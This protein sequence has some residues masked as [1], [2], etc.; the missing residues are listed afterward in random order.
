MLSFHSIRETVEMDV[1]V[2]RP[3]LRVNISEQFTVRECMRPS[4]EGSVAMDL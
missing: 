3:N 4:F 2:V 1:I